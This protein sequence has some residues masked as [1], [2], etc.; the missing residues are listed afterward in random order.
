M[1]NCTYTYREDL[2]MTDDEYL[3]LAYEE[4]FG[5]FDNDAVETEHRIQDTPAF[6][7]TF[8]T[9]TESMWIH[10]YPGIRS[11]VITHPATG[12]MP[13]CVRT[14]P[15]GWRD[16]ATAETFRSRFEAT[17]ALYASEGWSRKPHTVSGS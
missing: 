7:R 9:Y 11:I 4:M 17:V 14:V 2:T 15:V 10:G 12:G 6:N 5:A 3:G 13:G 1:S 16:M 8:P